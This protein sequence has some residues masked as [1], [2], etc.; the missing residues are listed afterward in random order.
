MRHKSLAKQ[1]GILFIIFALATIIISGVMTFYNQNVQ[2]HEACIDNLKQLTDYLSDLIQSNGT[3]FI[4]LKKW[5]SQHTK[6]VQIPKDFANELPKAQKKFTDYVK[7]NYPDKTFGADLSFDDLDFNAQK[8]Y[9]NYRFNYWFNVFFNA[10]DSF[11]LSYVYFIYPEDINK[12]T[13]NYMFDPTMELTKT[14][15][16]REILLLGYIAY[17]DP[18]IHV[19][20]WKA[21]N[22]DTDSDTLTFD[23]LDNEFGYVYTYCNLLKINGEKV[24]LVCAEISVDH[25]NSDILKSVIQQ[26]AILILVLAISTF[27]MYLFIKSR[28]LSRIIRLEGDIA[29][30]SNDKNPA[31]AHVIQAHRGQNDEIG[32]LSDK[33]AEMINELDVYMKNLQA[34]TAEKER[35]TAELN[36]AAN[37]QSDMLPRIFPKFPHDIKE[38]AI[39][40]TM[41][42]AKEVGGDFYDFF[43]VDDTH[44]ALVIAD[45]SG[46]G[47]PAALFMVIA[48]TLIKNRLQ[49]G[50][51]PANALAN[52]NEQLCEGNEAGFFVTVWAGVIDIETGHVIEANAGHEYPAIRRN[53][54]EFELIKTKHSP[55]VAVM[56][57]MKFRQNEFDLHH[58]DTLFIYTD[59]VTEATNADHELFGEERLVETLNRYRYY[60]PWDLLPAVRKDINEFVGDAPQ[61]DDMTMLGFNYYGSE[62]K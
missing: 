13:M 10:K 27:M 35:I 50:E 1:F 39:Y 5:F 9:V 51:A 18:A 47:V 15:D 24:G 6:E 45:V 43:M 59:G 42:P 31:V 55:A 53:D 28:I 34:V 3:E 48:K 52:V 26:V 38:Y 37:I 7:S 36:V 62:G 16:G 32:N 30:Y 56:E 29:S 4:T 20:M 17:E 54:G 2:Y 22:D 33:F 21:W 44:I 25:V 19:N 11:N 57:G 23:T 12:L 14:D 41:N 40:A 49:T 8:L 58:G 46:K 60:M 61:F